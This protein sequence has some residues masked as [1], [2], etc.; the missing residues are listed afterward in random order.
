MEEQR[1][2]KEKLETLYRAIEGLFQAAGK[3][4]KVTKIRTINIENGLIKFEVERDN[5]IYRRYHVRD[6]DD[7]SKVATEM[8]RLIQSG[9]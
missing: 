7:F 2:K 5:G 8:I 3:S 1:E 6:V 4:E 9:L